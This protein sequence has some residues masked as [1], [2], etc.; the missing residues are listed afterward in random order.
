MSENTPPSIMLVSGDYF[1]PGSPD[2]SVISLDVLSWSL[3]RQLRF[4]G[5]LVRD[6]TIA[7]HSMRVARFA[8]V[9]RGRIDPIVSVGARG[10]RLHALLHDAHEAL[11]PWGDCLSP[12]KTHAMKETERRIDA[13]ICVGL[14]IP[15]PTKVE[16]HVVK[17]AD[18]YA[19]YFEAML[20]QPRAAD[21]APRLGP[22]DRG[23]LEALMPEVWPRPG[24]DW[25]R[26][27]EVEVW[28]A[29]E[30]AAAPVTITRS[31]P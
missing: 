11:T 17:K 29:R 13:A 8:E 14:G 31:A 30:L 28:H 23:L 3:N 15:E 1:G 5:H 25:K 27:T 2:P 18:C 19:L 22:D 9:I 12:G 10:L 4:N 6:V 20:W 21:W 26:L 24:E 16:R 7:E